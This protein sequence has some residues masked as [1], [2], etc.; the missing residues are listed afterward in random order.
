MDSQYPY[1]VYPEPNQEYPENDSP[2]L[3]FAP[4]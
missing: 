2:V 4:V 3:P 1:P